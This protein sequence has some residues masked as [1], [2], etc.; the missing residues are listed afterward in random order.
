M[1]E[2]NDYKRRLGTLTDE[3]NEST[4]QSYDQPSTSVAHTSSNRVNVKKFY[5]HYHSHYVSE[6]YNSS[7][8]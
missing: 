3:G 7:C 1:R 8:L 2:L 5:P 6:M 4:Q